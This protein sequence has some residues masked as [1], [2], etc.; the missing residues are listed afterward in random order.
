MIHGKFIALAA[1]ATMALPAVGAQAADQVKFMFDWI[2]SGINGT[3]YAGRTNGCFEEQD[4]EFV[5][6]RGAGGVDTVS[7]VA[8]GLAD[9]GRADL[10]T[11]MLGASGAGAK[12]KAILPVYSISPFAV[13]TLSDSGINGLKDLEGRVLAHGPGDSAI[14]MLPIAMENA[15]ADL[16]KVK[17]ETVDFSALLGLL[18]Q[19]KSDAQ[20]TFMTTGRILQNVL[21]KAGKEG[22]LIH[23]G[24]DLDMYG[25]VV[26]ASHTFLD[27]RPEVA[28]R[29][30]KA[31][32]CAYLKGKDDPVTI[33]DALLAEFP[34]KK[35]DAEEASIEAALDLV[36]D[37]DVF[38]A[39][40]FTW[41]MERVNAT[42]KN[43]KQAQGETASGDASQFIHSFQ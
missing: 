24:E 13:L 16:S 10:G 30:N 42:F 31:L 29:A 3:L 33:A 37:N 17:T 8:S 39:N 15:G 22:T 21:K 4:I 6:D 1:A 5:F 2:P 41:D 43:A 34:E 18:I 19:G 40:G 32:Q 26:F 28:A 20:T 9:L 25:S 23:F 36:F 11:V 12:V 27:T 38:K 35:R 7:K 14:Q